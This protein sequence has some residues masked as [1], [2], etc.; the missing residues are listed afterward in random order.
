VSL[1][2][3]DRG[4]LVTVGG[5]WTARCEEF[6]VAKVVKFANSGGV[7]FSGEVVFEWKGKCD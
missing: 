2:L 4:V 3:R 7:C 5:V 6:R 1:E